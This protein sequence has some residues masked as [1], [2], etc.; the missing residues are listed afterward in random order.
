MKF[1][2]YNFENKTHFVQV[3]NNIL[4]IIIH[5]IIIKVKLVISTTLEY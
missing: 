4:E 1:S 2:K 5:R 3:H